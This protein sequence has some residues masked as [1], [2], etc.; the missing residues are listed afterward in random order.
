MLGVVSDRLRGLQF[1]GNTYKAMASALRAAMTAAALYRSSSSFAPSIQ[2]VVTGQLLIGDGADPW[3]EAV[4]ADTREVDPN[5]LLHKFS[6]WAEPKLDESSRDVHVLVTGHQLQSGVIGI[7]YF[8]D[9]CVR[10]HTAA[11][12]QGAGLPDDML[13]VTLA[14]ELGHLLGMRHDEDV[15][16]PAGMIMGAASSGSSAQPSSWSSCSTSAANAWYGLASALVR[17]PCY[18]H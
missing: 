2:L 3:G 16:C 12:V 18:R 8:S 5:D 14:H 13:A 15:A 6:T 7:A 11:V 9:M 17:Y 10:S 4:R 1:A